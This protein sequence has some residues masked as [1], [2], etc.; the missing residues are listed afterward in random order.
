VSNSVN[1]GT[2]PARARDASQRPGTFKPGHKKLGGRKKGTPNLISR[3]YKMALREAADRIGSDGNG[4]DGEVGYFTW[5]AKRFFCVDIW[6]RLLDLEEY[7]DAMRAEA[8]PVTDALRE[9]VHEIQKNKARRSA[10][11]KPPRPVIGPPRGDP[12]DLVQSLMRLAVERPKEFLK[13]LA[14]VWLTPPKNWR[15]RAARNRGF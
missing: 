2:T 10:Q 6:L 7:E 12:T 13:C 14:A 4:K 9:W 3:E 5:A 1:R 15:A 8:P 11:T